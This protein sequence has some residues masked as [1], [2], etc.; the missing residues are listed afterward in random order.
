MASYIVNANGALPVDFFPDSP[1]SKTDKKLTK[2]QLIAD[3]RSDVILLKKQLRRAK[4][5]VDAYRVY[6]PI[7][8]LPVLA[9]HTPEQVRKKSLDAGQI[10]AE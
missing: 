9:Q 1:K 7:E 10:T 2:E 8:L 6:V 3:L 4:R 5:E